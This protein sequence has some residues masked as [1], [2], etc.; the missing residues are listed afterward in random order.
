[1]SYTIFE[2]YIETGAVTALTYEERILQKARLSFGTD[3]SYLKEIRGKNVIPFVKIEYSYDYSNNPLADLYYTSEGTADTYHL[4]LEGVEKE[5]RW[6]LGFGTEIF[7]TNSE[8]GKDATMVLGYRREGG[9]GSN[10]VSS[11]SIYFDFD[12]D[13]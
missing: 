6:K 7:N 5:Q 9:F 4:R 12:W 8:I 13:F 2:K 11:E 1:M 3:I 10:F